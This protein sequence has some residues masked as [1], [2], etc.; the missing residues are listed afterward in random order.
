VEC[1]QHLDPGGDINTERNG[2]NAAK[3]NYV[4]V[5]GNIL[6]RDLQLQNNLSDFD[7]NRTGALNDDLDRI[8]AE[9]PGM[10]FVNSEVT[11]GEISDGTSNTFLVGERDSLDLGNEI[12]GAATWGRAPRAQWMNQCLGPTSADPNFTINTTIDNRNAKWNPFASQHPGGAN[13]GRADGST[14]F[15]NETISGDV[16]EAFGTRAG[17]EVANDF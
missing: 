10:L 11:H 15:V 6:T 3:S 13:F 16:Y 8:N 4:G 1:D 7:N 5:C 9:F 17:G 12:R 14:E 2:G